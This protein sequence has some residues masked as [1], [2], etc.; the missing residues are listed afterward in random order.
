MTVKISKIGDVENIDN[1]KEIL[2]ALM[3]KL[4]SA[5]YKTELIKL[6]FILDYKY[7]QTSHKESGPTTVKYVKYNY[8]PYSD[9]FVEAFE[10]LKREGVILE[11]GL[12]FGEGFEL[13]KPLDINIS[14]DILKL[15]ENVVAEYG[16]RSLR[17]MK[18]FIYGLEEFKN[19]EFGKPIVLFS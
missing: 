1:L 12:P 5:K 17:E 10:L 13:V 18:E 11:V 9:S 3:S 14:S 15:L 19:T 2:V 7:C 16:N 4:A 8:G 6:C